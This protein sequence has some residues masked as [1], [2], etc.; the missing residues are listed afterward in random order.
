[1]Q[2]KRNKKSW[3]EKL[4]IFV[5]IV[6]VANNISFIHGMA[7]VY[8]VLMI[9]ALAAILMKSK[10]IHVSN[11][12]IILYLACLFSILFNDVPDIFKPYQRLFTFFMMTMLLSPFIISEVFTQF[13]LQVIATFLSLLRYVI[14]GS[15]V[16]GVLGMGYSRIYFQGI[17]N[18]SMVLGPFA[19]LCILFCIYQFLAGG[20]SRKKK[21][22][23]IILILSSLFCLLQAAS[24]TAFIAC[25]AAVAIFITLY[26]NK[27]LGKY[28]R[29]V[30][31]CFI[32][33]ALTF[34][35]WGQFLDKLEAK[36]SGNIDSLSVSSR[37]EHWEKRIAEFESS[38]MIGIGFASVDTKDTVGSN[39]SDDGQVETGSSWLCTLSMT[40]ILGFI[41]MTMLFITAIAK[42]WK[43]RSTTLLLSC[44]LIAI[45]SFWI[46]HMMAEG[47]IFAGGS[48][49]FFCVWILIG[50]MH[51]LPQNTKAAYELQHKL[52]K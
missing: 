46:L 12:M 7:S 26:Y 37:E 5:S 48:T 4:G 20:L 1:M 47:Y 32:I 44:F 31:G 50:I 23:Y 27:N 9:L 22:F 8:Y 51:G 2:Q 10:I 39:F 52:C 33:A 15:V 43:M 13:R 36:N 3:V 34:P 6:L 18:H 41:P 16:A 19:A 25:L 21:A 17:T 11:T 30:V 45:L 28:L 40:G 24:R 35:L 38:P 42:T 29:I 49:M 14:L